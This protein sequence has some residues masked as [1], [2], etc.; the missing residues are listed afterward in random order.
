MS[1]SL[2]YTDQPTTGN[3][4]A[5]PGTF[6][7]EASQDGITASPSQTQGG[8]Y[9]LRGALNRVST[10]ATGGDSVTLPLSKGG[11]KIWVTNASPVNPI[12]VFPGAQLISQERINN[13]APNSA[14]SLG[15]LKTV[16]FV[17]YSPTQWYTNPGI[18]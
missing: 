10:V 2:V 7:L 15:P 18:P 1:E 14:F 13:L 6:L 8:G 9:R 11:M 17:C 12:N 4:Q 16:V 3:V 5:G